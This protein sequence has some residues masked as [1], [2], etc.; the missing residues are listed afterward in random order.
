MVGAVLKIEIGVRGF[1]TVHELY[2]QEKMCIREIFG[3]LQ[4]SFT[5]N[6]K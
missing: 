5:M 6:I 1:E 3:S 4:T 2:Y